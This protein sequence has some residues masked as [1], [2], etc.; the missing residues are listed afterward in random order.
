MFFFTSDVTSTLPNFPSPYSLS[1]PPRPLLDL[2]NTT[3]ST[4]A[5][6]YQINPMAINRNS[7]SL[8]PLTMTSIAYQR[9]L[10]QNPN[11]LPNNWNVVHP[12]SDEDLN[13]QNTL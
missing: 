9:L 5:S 11:Q 4:T 2:D 7:G 1:T 8:D 6:N 13:R 12:F 3:S 10:A